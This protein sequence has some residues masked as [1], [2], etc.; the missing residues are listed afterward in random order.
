MQY[1]PGPALSEVLAQAE[2]SALITHD[3]PEAIKGAQAVA[4]AVFLGRTG[5]DSKT[6][7]KEIEGRFCYDLT[8]PLKSIR[9]VYSADETCQGSVP[10]A[11]RAFLEGVCASVIPW[12]DHSQSPRNCYQAAMGKQALGVYAKSDSVRTDTVANTMRL[13]V[14]QSR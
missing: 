3:H 1:I 4:T 7:K 12:P 2:R 5:N 6:I 9:P 13:I 8:T 14:R 11:L 10:Q